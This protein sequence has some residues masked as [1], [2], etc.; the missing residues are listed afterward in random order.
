MMPTSLLWQKATPHRTHICLSRIAQRL[1]RLRRGIVLEYA[2]TYF[3]GAAFDA[4][5][6]CFGEGVGGVEMGEVRGWREG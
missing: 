5:D 1:I 4:E 6:D 3:V 2:H